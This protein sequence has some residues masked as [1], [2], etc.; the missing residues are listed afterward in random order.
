MD[1][2]SSIF[3]SIDC[4]DVHHVTCYSNYYAFALKLQVLCNKKRVAMIWLLISSL[5]C[6]YKNLI[7]DVT[8][9]EELRFAVHNTIA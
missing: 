8:V 9:D 1:L 3:S 4:V 2:F 5:N 6:N 7:S